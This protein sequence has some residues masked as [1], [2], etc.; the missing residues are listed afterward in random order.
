MARS[1]KNSP[2]FLRVPEVEPRER[3]V[4]DYYQENDFITIYAK[5]YY[6]L[7]ILTC[8]DSYLVGKY[9]LAFPGAVFYSVKAIGYLVSQNELAIIARRLRVELVWNVK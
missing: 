7:A 3:I 9:L 5:E 6:L 1:P 4:V 2:E 8:P